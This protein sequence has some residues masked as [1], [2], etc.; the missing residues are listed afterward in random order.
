[1]N[2]TIEEAT[3]VLSRTPSVLRALLEN[4]PDIFLRSN[5]GPDTWSPYDVVGHLIH[6]EKTNWIPRAS[7]IVKQG[8]HY[9]FEP[10]NRTAMF[11]ENKGK[12]ITLLLEEFAT[13]RRESLDTL[14]SFYLTPDMLEKTGIHPDFGSVRLRELLATWVAHD[15]S[16]VGQIVRTMAKQYEA[17]VGPWKAYLSIFAKQR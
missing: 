16:H 15:L 17:E 11:E 14:H 6:A 13:A 10:F 12:P 3:E 1:M 5:E 7:G 4:L 9:N 2:Y 8:E